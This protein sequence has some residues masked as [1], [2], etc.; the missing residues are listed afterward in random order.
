M[1]VSQH[2]A[3]AIGILDKIDIAFADLVEYANQLE[4][5]K[6]EKAADE[7]R[8]LLGDIENW[9]SHT[10]KKYCLRRG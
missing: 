6:M 2:K 1:T 4:D 9:E 3:I 7:L 5:N 10:V 8:A